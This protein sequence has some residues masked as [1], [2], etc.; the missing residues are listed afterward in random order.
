[1]DKPSLTI[2]P[3]K[4]VTPKKEPKGITVSVNM[5]TDKMQLKLRAIAEHTTALADELDRIDNLEPCRECGSLNHSVSKVYDG[6]EL[7]SHYIE[8]HDCGVKYHDELPTRL[9]GSE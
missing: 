1:M 3:D 6:D 9:E 8:C 4:P 7:F 5:D 2:R